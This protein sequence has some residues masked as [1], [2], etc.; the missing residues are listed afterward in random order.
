MLRHSRHLVDGLHPA[1]AFFRKGREIQTG[2]GG[3]GG[4]EE[5]T[6]HYHQYCEKLQKIEDHR[7]LFGRILAVHRW[8]GYHHQNGRQLWNQPQLP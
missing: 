8:S 3:S 4:G 2:I 1:L 6:E 7:T 5:R